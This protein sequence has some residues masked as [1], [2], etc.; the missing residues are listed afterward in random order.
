[1]Q[2]RIYDRD[3]V[4]HQ[5]IHDIISPALLWQRNNPTLTRLPT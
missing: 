4:A 2:F 3:D 5:V 1:M